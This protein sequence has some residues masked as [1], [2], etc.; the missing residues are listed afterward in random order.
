LVLVGDSDGECPPPQSYEFWHALK[1]LGV[2]T[3]LVIYP[4]EGHMIIQPEHQ[5]DII[6]RA[7][8]WFNEYLH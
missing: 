4:R 1:T 2:T 3:Q 6:K 5:R 8:D 7:V